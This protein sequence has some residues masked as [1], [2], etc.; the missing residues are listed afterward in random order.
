MV[1]R[2]AVSAARYWLDKPYDYLIPSELEEKAVP[3]TRVY[4]PF[5]RGNRKTEGII[6]AVSEHSD[7]DR[8][9]SIIR[10]LD[11]EPVLSEEQIKLALFMRFLYSL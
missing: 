10:V 4:V 9:K 1:A 3:G 6:L 5:S 2:I 7:Y 8:L 11:D